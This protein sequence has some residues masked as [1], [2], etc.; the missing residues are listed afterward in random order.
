LKKGVVEGGGEFHLWGRVADFARALGDA[1]Q[2]DEEGIV[3]RIWAKVGKVECS[4]G[5][6]AWAE[7]ASLEEIAGLG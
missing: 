4:V 5:E 6:G 3:V 7:G 2:V 1:L